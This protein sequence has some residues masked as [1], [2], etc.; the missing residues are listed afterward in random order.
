MASPVLADQGGHVIGLA[1]WLRRRAVRSADR[2]ALTCDDVTWT[3]REFQARIERLAAALSATGVA[4]G[5]RVGY[6][7]FNHPMFL[8]GLFAAARLGAIFVPLNFRLT[9][10]EIEFAVN[11]SGI[12][13]LLVGAEH[14]AI[15]ETIRG[16]LCCER[17]LS[18]DPGAAG[19]QAATDLME[20]AAPVAEPHLYL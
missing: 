20:T 10:P 18:V 1:E 13:T 16:S 17:Y 12:R 14:L 8:V 9:G 19:W 11:D 6:L 15:I 3:Y 7:G 4:A 5:D 2:P